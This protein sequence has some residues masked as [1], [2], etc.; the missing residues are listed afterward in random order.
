M[1]NHEEVPQIFLQHGVSVN[2]ISKYINPKSH[3]SFYML[4]SSMKEKERLCTSN[5]IIEKSHIWV[6]GL[7]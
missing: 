5:Y 3:K 4:A 2:D 6:T 7:P 1:I